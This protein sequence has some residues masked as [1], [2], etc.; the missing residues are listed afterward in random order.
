MSLD[1][2]RYRIMT[3]HKTLLERWEETRLVWQDSVRA[4]FD[5]DHLEP[6]A[7]MLATTLGAIDQLAQVLGRLR[8]ECS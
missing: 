5:R 7:P 8:Q 1:V 3:A 4:E 6:L 2:G